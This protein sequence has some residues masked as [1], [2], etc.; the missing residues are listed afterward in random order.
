MI[1][2]DLDM[3]F[4]SS[5]LPVKDEV[6]LQHDKCLKS[7]C[8]KCRFSPSALVQRLAVNCLGDMLVGVFNT[9]VLQG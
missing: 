4:L 5:S 3:A 7:V 2:V 6:F 8:C 1:V 9:L